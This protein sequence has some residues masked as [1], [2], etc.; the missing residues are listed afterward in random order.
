MLKQSFV[1]REAFM[2]FSRRV[3]MTWL[4]SATVCLSGTINGAA[5]TASP[6]EPLES[7]QH[8]P[9][10]D[11]TATALRRAGLPDSIVIMAISALPVIE[12]RGG[13][14]AGH[15]LMMP[16]DRFVPWN[17]RLR[18]SARIF[19]LAVIGN[20]IPVPF[21]LWLLG[22]AADFCSRAALGRR[23]FD[24]LFAR[25]RRKTA[26]VEKYETLGLTIFVAVPLPA[27][28]AWTGAMVAFVLGMSFRHAMVSI[29]AGVLVAGVIM[30]V[31]SLLGWLGAAMA[32]IVLLGMAVS[33]MLKWLKKESVESTGLQSEAT[34]NQG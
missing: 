18:I 8:V 28:G 32:G 24:W 4:V 27:T 1:R 17:T 3:L 2:A 14:P 16:R 15:T 23:F 6:E 13:I 30:T 11:R 5:V 31:L 34:K 20:M 25:T 26:E 7:S 29:L 19:L 9:L 22:P 33:A 10:A 12:L 21:I